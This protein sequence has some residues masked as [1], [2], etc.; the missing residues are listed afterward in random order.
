MVKRILCFIA[1]A[2]LL[3]T[4]PGCWDKV[5]IDQRGF[6]GVIMIDMAPPDYTEKV[7]ESV[8]GIPNVEKQEGKMI[9]VT[10]AFPITTALA[11]EGGVGGGNKPAFITISSIATTMDKAN[12]YVDSRISRRLFF[13]FTQAII[14]GE[15]FLKNPDKVKEVLDYFRR[16]PEFGRYMRVLVAEGE[17]S[18]VAE[19]KPKGEI[20]LSRYLRGVLNNEASS[21]RI[22]DMGFNEFIVMLSQ[23]KCA[24]LPKLKVGDDELKIAG[25]GLIKDYS[26]VGYLPE[27]DSLYFNALNGKRKSGSVSLNVNGIDTN[28]VIRNTSR[29]IE[30]INGDPGDLKIGINIITEGDLISGEADIQLFDSEMINRIEEDFNKSDVENYNY[31]I[32]KLQKDFNMDALGISDYLRKYHPD[33]WENI[34]DKWESIYP[35]IK[36]IPFADNKIRRIGTVK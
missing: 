19:I 33:V 10:Y 7:K 9:K 17:A 18:K 5:E 30:L 27:Y 23:H 24:V 36:I 21:G 20:L 1:A 15:E 6:V 4:L 31:V 32:K 14:F 2:I 35:D 34:E 12:S 13:G 28:Y 25:L 22:F 16:N 29:K 3:V 11:S 8:V 26:L